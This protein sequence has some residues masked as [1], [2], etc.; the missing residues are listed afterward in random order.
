MADNA[1]LK[2]THDPAHFL[3][4]PRLKNAIFLPFSVRAHPAK[5]LFLDF[6]PIK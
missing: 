1:P 4:A 5:G 3:L 6:P 2:T